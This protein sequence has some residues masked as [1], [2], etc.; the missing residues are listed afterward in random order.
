MALQSDPVLGV[1]YL[2]PE[3]FVKRAHVFGVG[4]AIQNYT[5]EDLLA[6]LADASRRVDEICGRSFA[7]EPI[8]ELHAWN[9]RTRRVIVNSPPVAELVSFKLL[10]SNEVVADFAVEDVFYSEQEN[11]LELLSFSLGT[12]I[13]TPLLQYGLTQVQ[14]EVVYKSHQ[15]PPAAVLRATGM[16]AA[17]R[18]NGGFVNALV[19][20]Q[21]GTLKLGGSSFNNVQV[22]EPK[23]I[24]EAL[25]DFIR[26]PIA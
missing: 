6:L 1:C 23:A 26:I 16:I 11:Y 14:A 13:S 25:A 9:E 8:R 24:R 2:D 17:H 4:M 3:A 12:L 15:T 7:P 21:F 18:A 10:S 20:A 19:P 5:R 22:E